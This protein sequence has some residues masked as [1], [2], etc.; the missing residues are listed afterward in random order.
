MRIVFKGKL[1]IDMET[2][3]VDQNAGFHFVPCV[4]L[5]RVRS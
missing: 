2:R 1:R 4:V 5:G 3:L